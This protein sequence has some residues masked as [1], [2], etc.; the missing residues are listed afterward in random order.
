MLELTSVLSMLQSDGVVVIKNCVPIEIIKACKAEL[1][2]V[3]KSQ[4]ISSI[5][6]Y[7]VGHL[8]FD[9]GKD[10]ALQI[11]Q[12]M[13]PKLR[14]IA[15]GYLGTHKLRVSIIGNLNLPQSVEQHWHTDGGELDR[16]LIVNIIIDDFTPDNGAT[17]Y[18]KG[19]HR[20]FFGFGGYLFRKLTNRFTVEVLSNVQAGS[21]V[22][23]DST[24]WH[25][26]GKNIT[27]SP[28]LMIGLSICKSLDDVFLFHENSGLRENW[29]GSRPYMEAIYI[30]Y[31]WI[32]NLKRLL[33]WI[34]SKKG[35]PS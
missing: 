30:N 14:S 16:F 15:C 7:K 8:N 11:E 10:I 19:S 13:L 6:G 32:W 4:N 31:R 12:Q 17:E 3:L 29:F 21:L 2:H 27:D 1:K 9:C 18:S 22:L 23:R 26:G 5:P 25:R 35:Q 20:N 34:K 33:S 24:M 28:R